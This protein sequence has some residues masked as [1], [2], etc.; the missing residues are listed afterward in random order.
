MR[1]T[2][3]QKKTGAGA[4]LV[5]ALGNTAAAWAQL[6]YTP[7]TTPLYGGSASQP[8]EAGRTSSASEQSQQAP[9]SGNSPSMQASQ[10]GASASFTP[11]GAAAPSSELPARSFTFRPRVMVRE[12]Y[13]DN[14]HLA[15]ASRAQSDAITEVVPGFD[16]QANGNRIQGGLSYSLLGF[17]Y[18][19]H[20]GSDH[21]SN[22][23]S[24]NATGTIV[25]RHFF[26]AA[27]TSYTQAIIN[28]AASGSS[29]GL[30]TSGNTTNA[31]VSRVNPY[32]LQS[33]GPV[34]TAKLSYAFGNI[35]Y[36]SA[37]LVNSSSG[38]A[39]SGSLRNS[40]SNTYEASL[41]SPS[42]N[43]DWSWSGDY[44]N[45]QESIADGREIKQQSINGEI[46]YQILDHLTLLGDGGWERNEQSQVYSQVFQGSMWAA[47]FRWSTPFNV[48]EFKYGHRFFGPTYDVSWQHR[49]ARVTTNLSYKETVS[50]VTQDLQA[51]A[52]QSQSLQSQAVPA[53]PNVPLSSL[54]A[55]DIYVSKRFAG[56]IQYSYSKTS[57]SLTG[58][59]ERRNYLTR[60]VNEHVTGATLAGNWKAGA[61][62]AVV[63]SF[64][65]E[66]SN[67]QQGQKSTLFSP[68]VALTYAIG[69]AAQAEVGY[70]YEQRNG[71][72][73]TD[74]YTM[75]MI[76][77]QFSTSF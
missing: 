22:Q 61:R 44:R 43:G 14:I 16:L 74:S 58:Y 2:A 42:D 13:S 20:S 4:V 35:Q 19:A 56:S 5:L 47:G 18:A 71:R 11:E 54:N 76:Y 33:L 45:Y 55:F 27:N 69:G 24:A 75:N 67:Y 38:N 72:A 37:G 17:L 32:W 52:L 6:P 60:Q 39:G 68:Q 31:W 36:S 25:P 29:N 9:S 40:H 53:L 70:R 64:T 51:Q 49:A 65:W 26:L 46:G 28:P 48:F 23:V 62:T 21:V 34:G 1:I 41:S 59:D 7:L 8:P 66:Q 30:F 57:L 50:V 77:A 73:Q 15:P 12:T 63:P 3:K 10:P